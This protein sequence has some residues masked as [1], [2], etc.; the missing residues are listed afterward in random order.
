MSLRTARSSRFPAV[1]IEFGE[2]SEAQ[3]LLTLFSH[4]VALDNNDGGDDMAE[5]AVDE[6]QQWDSADDVDE[7][8]ESRETPQLVK[9]FFV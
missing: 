9:L 3:L 6:T 2:D 4:F 7:E 1:V 5:D 8:Q